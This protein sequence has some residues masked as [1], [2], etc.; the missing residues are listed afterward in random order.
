M[1]VQAINLTEACTMTSQ[2]S[3]HYMALEHQEQLA[4]QRSV[5]KVS[6]RHLWSQ[7]SQQRRRYVPTAVQPSSAVQENC[8]VGSNCL[9]LNCL[10]LRVQFYK[11]TV[12]FVQRVF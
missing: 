6:S 11:N 5:A 2:D 1:V 12:Y 8:W 4:A 7:W 9:W 3:V 10:H